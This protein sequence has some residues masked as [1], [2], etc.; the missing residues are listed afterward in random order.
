MN[1][2]IIYLTILLNQKRVRYLLILTIF[3][4][5]FL[6]WGKKELNVQANPDLAQCRADYRN[7][8]LQDLTDSLYA[9]GN[10]NGVLLVA[11]NGKIV[12]RKAFGR[13][14]YNPTEKFTVNTPMQ[15]ASVS[16]PFT[17]VAALILIERGK[18]NYDDK[19]TKYFPQ[20]PYKKV[21][22][23][24]LLN[25][26]SGIPCYLNQKWRFKKHFYRTKNVSNSDL[27]N[28]LAHHHPKQFFQEGKRHK[29]SN[30]GYALLASVIE[31]ASGQKFT[32]FVQKNIFNVAG[33]PNT[34]FFSRAKSKDKKLIMK[35][36]HDALDGVYGDKGI[37]STVDD[38]LAWDQALYSDKL[39]SQKTLAKAYQV[40]K[41]EN[42][43]QDEFNYGHGW[44][45]VRT[46]PYEPII[47][48]KGLWQGANP[49]L[50]RFV[51]C[52][53]TVISLHP[54]DKFNS[55]SMTYAIRDILNESEALCYQDF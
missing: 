49:M 30:T 54:A 32:D 13:R 23:R 6:F 53:R 37:F 38:M 18:L 14:K 51:G 22:I 3:M 25:H 40:G 43:K 16:K 24:Q 31:K 4:L 20:L 48:H 47:Y 41:L 21:T 2:M 42:D 11:E 50:I 1:Y 39:V 55:W 8:M 44:R 33:M 12:F 15:L 7:C 28:Y 36:K 5:S 46:P 9:M 35:R 34:F 27:V 52:N 45:M 19:L 26:T 10:Y 17:A 29:Y